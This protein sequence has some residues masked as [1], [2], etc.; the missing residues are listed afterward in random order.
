MYQ[1]QLAI[2]SLNKIVAVQQKFPVTTFV[3]KNSK[4]NLWCR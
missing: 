1:A 4:Y 2:S 3:S